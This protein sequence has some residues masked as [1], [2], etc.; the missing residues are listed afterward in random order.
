MK[1]LFEWILGILFLAFVVV[2]VADWLSKL[3]INTF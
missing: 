3:S 2:T 1:T